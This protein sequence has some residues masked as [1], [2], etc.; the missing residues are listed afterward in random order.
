MNNSTRPLFG[1]QQERS[2]TD[3][4]YTPAWIFDAM[5]GVVFDVDVAAPPG[6]VPW[7]PA[8]RYLTKAEDGLAADWDGLVWMN[9]PFSEAGQWLGRFLDHGLGVC[10]LPVAK[11]AWFTDQAWSYLDGLVALPASL[12]FVVPGPEDTEASNSIPYQCV[13]GAMGFGVTAL[14]L[15][16]ERFA[17]RVR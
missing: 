2:T 11:S 9:P 7:L 12:R 10:L 1:H 3:D 15:F 4:W 6:G 14:E 5:P 16:A 17:Y 13:L 8:K